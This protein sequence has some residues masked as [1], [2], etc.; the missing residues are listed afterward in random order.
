MSSQAHI[1]ANKRRRK[2]SPKASSAQHQKKAGRKTNN[3]IH[4]V[5]YG[6]DLDVRMLPPES[7]IRIPEPPSRSPTPPT[8]IDSGPAGNRYTPEDKSYFIKVSRNPEW[9]CSPASFQSRRASVGSSSAIPRL[10]KRIC[11]KYSAK[12]FGTYEDDFPLALMADH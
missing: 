7:Y 8:Y 1:S 11:Y 9:F 6:E 12:R 2:E 5:L 4:S 10:T 3:S